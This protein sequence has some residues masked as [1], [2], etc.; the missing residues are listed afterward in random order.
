M[1]D[2]ITMDD[3]HAARRRLAGRV[4]HTPLVEVAPGVRCKAESLQRS[5]SFKLRGAYNSLLLLDE[6]QRRRGAV[7][8]SSGN[9]AAAVAAAGADLG[10]PVTVVMPADAPPVKRSNTEAFGA[11]VVEVG[12]D[13]DERA[14]VAAELAE[15]H[16]WA[17]V[18]PY[19]SQ[20]VLAATATIGVEVVEDL[21]R[22]G[23]DPTA[24]TVYVPLSG[25]GLAGGVATAVHALAP[26]ARVV[27]VEPEVAADGLESWRAGRRVALPAE[28]MA[29]TIADGLRVRQLGERPWRQLRGRLHDVVTVS[30]DDIV[31]TMA[32]LV[33]RC[34]LVAEPS[35]AVA[36][37][38]ALAHH[39]GAGVS[40]ALLSGRNVEPDLLRAALDP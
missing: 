40:V 35:G 37:A 31:A 24:M 15:E 12:P 28:R 34:G 32:S 5:G 33:R 11:T 27:G 18:E 9:H 14:R 38:A 21:T 2:P 25:G 20:A 17:L 36:P 23:H 19:D 16:G 1:T 7:A 4:L 3:V 39:R 26:G 30:E 13:S 10:V 29:R 8:H 6:D 22:T